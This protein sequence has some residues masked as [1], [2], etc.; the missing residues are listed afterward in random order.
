MPSLLERYS[1]KIAGTLS[2]PD[3]IIITGTIPGICY[4]GGMASYLTANGIRLFDYPRFAE[5][6]RDELCNNAEAIAREHGIEIEFIRSAKAFRKE[7]RI[8]QILQT[9]GEEPGM[10]HIFSAMEPCTAYR[11]W[12]D[13][14]TGRT[15]LKPVDGKCKHYYFY[16][17]DDDYGLCYMRVP[18][19]AP[20]RLQFY[21]NGHGYLARQL[22]K[23]S[24]EFTQMDNTFLSFGDW[25]IAQGLA[26]GMLA[27]PLHRA[28]DRWASILCPVSEL[29]LKG[30]H[31]SIM[32]CELSFDIVFRRQSD[33]K[34]IYDSLS[35]TAIHAVKCDNV[36][37]FLGRK[38]DSRYK[39]ELGNDFHTRVEGTRIK[40]RMGSASIKM[41]DKQGIVL[42]IE[43]TVND[44]TIFRHYRTVEHRDGTTEKKIAAMQKT[45]YS[46]PA[47]FE[48]MYASNKRYL[49]FI[50]ALDDPTASL[51]DV[52]KITSPASDKNGRNYAGFN[53]FSKNDLDAI[54]ALVRGEGV[55]NG[56]TNKMLRKSLPG[57]TT[58]QVSRLLKRMR[59]HGLI[60]KVAKSFKY[61]LTGLGR[62]ALLTGLK[63]REFL[64]IPLMNDSEAISCH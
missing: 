8:K 48:C 11:P 6:L 50:S 31:W 43:T 27:E 22:G 15:M 52:E 4:A 62:R 61:Y 21:C 23:G 35:R 64:V 34:P 10:V 1:D 56:I 24:V 9:R 26:D 20:F 13:K 57:K 51:K 5:P 2:C 28:L 33:L 49:E 38:L 32:Q 18:T 25:S 3:R 60:K 47:L 17:I 16:F 54:V 37:T 63:L 29:F 7:D 42:R 14:A 40:H 44:V 58:V 45:I 39:D 55:I 30:Y 41:Y 36:A 19:W 59:M 46:L 12:H 53:F